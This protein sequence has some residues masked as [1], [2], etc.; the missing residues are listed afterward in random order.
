MAVGLFTAPIFYVIGTADFLHSFFSTI[1]YRLEGSDWGSR[2]PVLMNELF[3]DG[4]SHTQCE[5]ALQE[6]AVI[7]KE[8]TAL[9]TDQ[10]VWD[11]EDLSKQ[12]PW[13]TDI[14]PTITNLANYFVTSDGKQLI[15][16]FET[17]LHTSISTQRPLIIRSM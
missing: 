4:I 10:L 8:L 12:P 2:F 5:A 14:A 1:V 15:T 16:V 11:I 13:G 7:K 6:L 17:A 9:S 3:I